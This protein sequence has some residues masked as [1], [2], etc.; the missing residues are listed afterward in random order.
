MPRGKLLSCLSG[1]THLN[2]SLRKRENSSNNLQSRTKTTWTTP[3]FVLLEVS[4]CRDCD[5]GSFISP[6]F[7][8]VCRIRTDKT[9]GRIRVFTYPLCQRFQDTRVASGFSCLD[10]LE[11][12][13]DLPLFLDLSV[14]PSSLLLSRKVPKKFLASNPS[15][16]LASALILF[17]FLSWC[18]LSTRATALEKSK[19][20]APTVHLPLALLARLT[21]LNSFVIWPLAA[22]LLD[23]R[24]DN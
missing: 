9:Y 5:S 15:L 23:L 17:F 8:R 16:D 6:L 4:N 22:F 19:C 1:T 14:H 11:E 18:F 10:R 20:R 21:K 24:R 7:S 12:K 2:C 3:S 13:P